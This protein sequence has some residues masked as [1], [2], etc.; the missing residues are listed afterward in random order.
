[1]T[2]TQATATNRSEHAHASSATPATSLSRVSGES[3]TT[4]SPVELFENQMMKQEHRKQALTPIIL[5]GL[6]SKMTAPTTSYVAS[7]YS[8]LDVST[9]TTTTELVQYTQQIRRAAVSR[10]RNASTTAADS[11]DRH[12][13][14]GR[15]DCRR[16]VYVHPSQRATGV[17]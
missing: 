7:A 11:T 13:H 3:N 16:P 10:I 12:P 1:M 14:F 2:V 5:S 6:L 17:E 15:G 4:A 8:P 9:T